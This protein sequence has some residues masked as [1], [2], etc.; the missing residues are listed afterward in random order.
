MSILSFEYKK[1][2]IKEKALLMV[3]LYL[4]ITSAIFFYSNDFMLDAKLRS[5]LTQYNSY[6]EQLKGPLTNEKQDYLAKEKQRLTESKMKYDKAVDEYYYNSMDEAL[7]VEIVNASKDN[8]AKNP[9]FEIV[10]DQYNFIKEDENNRDFIPIVGITVIS[11]SIDHEFDILLFVLLTLITVPL[12]SYEYE[13]GMYS[14]LMTTQ[15]GKH[16]LT[17]YKVFI[18]IINIVFIVFAKLII[19]LLI[20]DYKY[21]MCNL[22]APV[23]SYNLLSN[24]PFNLNFL[25]LF[26]ILSIFDIFTYVIFSQLVLT[27]TYGVKKTVYALFIPMIYILAV[28]IIVGTNDKLKLFMLSPLTFLNSI[29]IFTGEYAEQIGS[30]HYT[31]FFALLLIIG[32]SVCVLM[33]LVNIKL[34]SKSRNKI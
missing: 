17:S 13:S 8:V 28:N 6:I 21:G 23:Q 2:M 19:R 31:Y 33:C 20:T 24:I 32:I 15:K 9:A 18:S 14:L 12:F 34:F 3:V 25:E 10:E 11:S 26:I 1:L 16:K 4:L 5:N 7:F 27:I 30:N 22:F 29:K